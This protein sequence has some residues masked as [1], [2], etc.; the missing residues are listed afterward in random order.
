MRHLLF[1]SLVFILVAC[2]KDETPTIYEIDTFSWAYNGR[3]YNLVYKDNTSNAG[4]RIN[5]NRIPAISFDMVDELGGS[6]YFEKACA[7]LEPLGSI[8]Y[9]NEGCVLTE[10]DGTGNIIP[11]DSTKVYIYQS[12]F[13]NISI[14]NCTK[15]T[16]VDL[17][18]GDSYQYDDCTV[19]GT[20]DLTLVNKEDATIK[21][22]DGIVILNHVLSR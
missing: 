16:A 20:F 19:S 13:F 17:L 4:A 14:S 11:I 3:S 2:S 15:K 5:M 6:I 8:I 1:I 10:K 12:G 18:T 9:E 7:Y 21:I 22:T